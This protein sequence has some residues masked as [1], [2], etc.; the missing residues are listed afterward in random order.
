VGELQAT[1]SYNEFLSWQ[2][3]FAEAP[4]DDHHRYHRPAVLISQSMVGGDIKEKFD[5]L[6]PPQRAK[7]EGLEDF[8]LQ[9]LNA[10]GIKPP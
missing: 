3:Y 8:D 1:M 2:E 7:S 10:F 4:F 6:E 5:F 9:T